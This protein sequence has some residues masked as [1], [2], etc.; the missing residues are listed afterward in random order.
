MENIATDFV[1]SLPPDN[2]NNQLQKSHAD[3]L[4]T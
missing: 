1:G 2:N 3:L 4:Y